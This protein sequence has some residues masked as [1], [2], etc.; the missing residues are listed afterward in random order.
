MRVRT[1]AACAVRLG[2]VRGPALMCARCAQVRVR[3][4]RTLTHCA[5]HLGGPVR[6]PAHPAHC[7]SAHVAPR[8][9]AHPVLVSVRCYEMA[10]LTSA[11]VW[12]R[13]KVRVRIPIACAAEVLTARS[14]TNSASP[15]A[16][17]RR[18]RVRW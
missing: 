18:L 7:T 5:P 10:F 16:T 13:L 17:P 12:A 4:V 2:T 15:G 6:T 14:S 11:V 3:E 1:G 9:C 8:T